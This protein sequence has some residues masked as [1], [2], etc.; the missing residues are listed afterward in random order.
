MSIWL[1]LTDK[2]TKLDARQNALTCSH[3]GMIMYMYAT[4]CNNKYLDI[5]V[6]TSHDNSV[7]SRTI[8]N[9]LSNRCP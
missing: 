3:P 5:T 2:Q 6:Y 9:D 4:R 8:I 7:D 1:L